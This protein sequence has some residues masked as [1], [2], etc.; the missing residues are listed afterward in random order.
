[1]RSALSK[2]KK[3]RAKLK[4]RIA[5]W[6]KIVKMPGATIYGYKKPGSQNK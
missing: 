3:K 1:M 5:Y 6:E 2:G 4:S